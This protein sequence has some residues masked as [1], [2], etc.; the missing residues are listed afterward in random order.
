MA[1]QDREENE[2]EEDENTGMLHLIWNFNLYKH[3]SGSVG[4]L[5]ACK[6]NF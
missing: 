6:E 1:E 5:Y 4:Q 3:F 2:T